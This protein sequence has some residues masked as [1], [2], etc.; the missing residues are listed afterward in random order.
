MSL[1]QGSRI[2]SNPESERIAAGTDTRAIESLL[3]G[4]TAKLQRIDDNLSD[5]ETVRRMYG[6]G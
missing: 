4:I 2:Y 5:M 6:Y 3:S 1:P